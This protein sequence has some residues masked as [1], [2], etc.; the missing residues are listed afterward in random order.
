[1]NKNYFDYNIFSL[2]MVFNHDFIIYIDFT[3]I[4]ALTQ[5]LIT[6]QIGSHRVFNTNIQYSCAHLKIK[7][8][9]KI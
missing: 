6:S 1:M 4:A 7:L 2:L 8:D 3:R 5:P 9:E